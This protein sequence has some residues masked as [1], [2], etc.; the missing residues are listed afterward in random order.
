MKK[1]IGFLILMMAALLLL[2]QAEAGAEVTTHIW[3]YGT[4][5][6]PGETRMPYYPD[7]SSRCGEGVTQDDFKITY[8][9][10]SGRDIKVSSDGV[11]TV[12]KDL[13]LGTY[14]MEITY[15]PKVTGVGKLSR[16]THAVKVI[17][18]V[19]KIDISEDTIYI[20]EGVKTSIKIECPYD[21]MLTADYDDDVISASC[22]LTLRDTL[23]VNLTAKGPGE[24]DLVME[25]YNGIVKI[26]RVVVAGPVTKAEYGSDHFVCYTGDTIDFG[27]D[28]GNGKYGPKCYDPSDY[29]LTRN[30]QTY[31]GVH[32][33][34]YTQFTAPESGEY[35]MAITV[36]GFKA[37]TKISVY[38]RADCA[39]IEL[40]YGPMTA[41]STKRVVLCDAQGNRIYRP[42]SITAGK[43]NASL[44]Y[45]QLTGLKPGEVIITVENM[46]GSTISETFTVLEK[47]TI[48]LRETLNITLEIGE[49]FD[50]IPDFG[51]LA[52]KCTYKFSGYGG[53]PE[54]ELYCAR[55]EGNTIVAQAPGRGTVTI[56]Y[57]DMVAWCTVTVPDSDKAIRIVMP[58]EPLGIGDTFQLTVQ[59]KTGKV[60]PA[61]FV[62]YWTCIELT[63]DGL[64]TAV[65]EGW[66][67]V[68][69]TLE[70]GRKL[71][72]EQY[73]IVQ[74]PQW[75]MHP[76]VTVSLEDGL[77]ELDTIT[78]D[79]GTVPKQRVIIEVEDE[80]IATVNGYALELHSAGKTVVTLTA[81]YG[82]AKT[83][84]TLEVL[85]N[86]KLFIG[87]KVMRLPSG[88][89]TSMPEVKNASGKVID[90]TWAI[91]HD[92]PGPGNPNASGFV[93]EG[94]RISCLWPY[95]SCEVTGTAKDG[96]TVKVTVQ[97]YQIVEEI[98]LSRTEVTLNPG[99]YERISVLWD[100]SAG[101][102][103][104]LAWMIENTDIVHITEH[105]DD[106]P[107]TVTVWGD[108][109]GVTQVAVMM[110]NGEYALCT[111]TVQDPNARTPGDA[112]ED[113]V[114]NAKDALLVMQYD[115]GWNVEINGWLG[116]V[117]A[118]GKTTIEDAVLIF[119]HSAGLDVVLK[120]YI[121]AE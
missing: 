2:F 3:A 13:K 110:A 77:C 89:T 11:I 106:T 5:V 66:Y 83:S 62:S 85:D 25:T 61:K 112:N 42:M 68:Y 40:E 1:K 80:S 51:V 91:T 114:V 15:T 33:V 19:R 24:T 121:P 102:I 70:D 94:D 46:D 82:G 64:L 74:R 39:S 113:G 76:A 54:D 103:S 107:E 60:Y 29:S 8:K 93:L 88:Y 55:M 65:K 16:F 10:V 37:S 44:Q 38:D 87:S 12:P 21:A 105:D 79:V 20:R 75:I 84:F 49:T 100:K 63:P 97:G 18:T 90:V 117:N 35:E 104:E 4:V 109:A 86:E 108:K 57:G 45:D 99:N 47:P 67:E 32:I 118:D 58:E 78:S 69:A 53:M 7:Y 9:A 56:E 96:K 41:G 72:S 116:D 14:Y 28:L 92:V 48:G 22:G 43:E 111:V 119:Q 71:R 27:L 98:A 23:V 73:Q 34:P 6:S 52:D 120:S 17:D 31:N 101:E 36:Q 95:S 115:A 26:L 81:V 30:G 59:D 50:L